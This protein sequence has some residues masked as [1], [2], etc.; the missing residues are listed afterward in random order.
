MNAYAD[1]RIDAKRDFKKKGEKDDR[2][3]IFPE[4]NQYY[5]IPYSYRQSV[6]DIHSNDKQL[7][8]LPFRVLSWLM[9][10]HYLQY[11]LE[12]VLVVLLL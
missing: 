11:K 9:E 4:F 5:Q 2:L 6:D 1:K 8:I 12:I 7:Q 3:T 10:H